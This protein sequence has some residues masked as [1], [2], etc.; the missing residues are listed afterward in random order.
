MDRAGAYDLVVLGETEPSV[1]EMVSGTVSERIVTSTDVPVI[2]VRHDNPDV[3]AA[4]QAT[5]AASS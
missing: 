5:Q 4:E 2:F 1:R 3:Q